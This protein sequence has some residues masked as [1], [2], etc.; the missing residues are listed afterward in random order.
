MSL[1]GEPDNSAVPG[2]LRES[3]PKGMSGNLRTDLKAVLPPDLFPADRAELLAYAIGR[4]VADNVRDAL[5]SLPRDTVFRSVT[6]VSDL[7]DAVPAPV[8][9][10]GLGR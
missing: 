5:E 4:H 10:D 8:C 1:S 6:A 2:S 9:L 3:P 7:A